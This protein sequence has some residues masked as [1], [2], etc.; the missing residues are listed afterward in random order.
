[1]KNHWKFSEFDFTSCLLGLLIGI[2]CAI[3]W[4]TFVSKPQE[5]V[6]NDNA[7]TS[8]EETEVDK[9]AKVY[10][11][12]KKQWTINTTSGEELHFTTPEDMYSLTDQYLENLASYYEMDSVTSDSMIV[13][14]DT[15]TPY[16]SNTIINANSLSDVKAILNQVYA[17][18]EDYKSD[19]IIDS[20]AYVYMTTGEIPEDAPDNFEISEVDECKSEDVTYKVFKIE[21][22]TTYEAEGEGEEA[23]TVHTQQLSAYSDTEDAIEI[24]INQAEFNQEEGIALLHEFLNV[25]ES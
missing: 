17:D 20:A 2:M 11:T 15:T 24:I 19:D 9:E 23:T 25:E 4:T 5:V 12:Q 16:Q 8:D 18:E 3:F 6:V 22:D 7:T 13:I 21:Y 14:G 1:M 10:E